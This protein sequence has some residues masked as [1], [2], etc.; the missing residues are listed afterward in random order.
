M[1]AISTTAPL[2]PERIHNWQHTQLSVSRHY[3]GCKYQ[4]ASYFIAYDEPGDPLVRQDVKQKEIRAAAEAAKAERKAAKQAATQ[5][6]AVLHL[7]SDD[8]EGGHVD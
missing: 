8:T 5:A 1:S 7:P 6:Q 3:G 4:G 2:P